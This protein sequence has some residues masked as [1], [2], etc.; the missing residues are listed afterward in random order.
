MASF[1][2]IKR[3]KVLNKTNGI[4]AHCG[5]E[6]N[7]KTFTVDHY[8]PKSKGGVSTIDN[9]IPLCEKCNVNK[10]NKILEPLV[11]Y[12]YINIKYENDL[13]RL[14]NIYCN[15][16]E[17]KEQKEQKSNKQQ[18]EQK[19]DKT[20]NYLDLSSIEIAEDMNKYILNMFL[21]K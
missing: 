13:I 3:Q 21:N 7:L 6:L 11:A 12:P 10:D 16:I 8:I 17:Q 19:I 14:Y 18:A 15:K 2:I 20:E 1:D 9:L 5:L 4:C